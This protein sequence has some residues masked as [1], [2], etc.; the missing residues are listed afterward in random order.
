[1]QYI[2]C[3]K[4]EYHDL[5]DCVKQMKSVILFLS[6]KEINLLSPREVN[7]YSGK[8]SFLV[9]KFCLFGLMLHV[10]VNSYGHVWTVS[11]PNLISGRE[12]GEGR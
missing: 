1:M 5:H 3:L 11:L 6:T 8:Y 9:L 10:P 4:E 2:I 7:L 12:S